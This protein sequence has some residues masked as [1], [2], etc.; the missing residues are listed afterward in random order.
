[1]IGADLVVMTSHGRTG[2]N[3]AWVGSVADGVLRRS[4]EPVL[5]C[6]PTEK[7][8]RATPFLPFRRILVPL[9]GSSLA[10]EILQSAV[11]LAICSGARLSL[12][13][14]VQPV[15]LLTVETAIP[16]AFPLPVE[17]DISTKRVA[18]RA[19]RELA[20]VARNL[21]DPKIG[22]IDSHVVIA[23]DVGAAIVDFALGSGIDAIAMSTHGR[24]ASRLL[25][26]SVADKVIRSAALPMLLKGPGTA[27]KPNEFE[28]IDA[29]F[30]HQ[31]TGAPTT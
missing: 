12:L 14:I 5:M 26:G 10:N 7:A 1:A 31:D 2:L 18:E 19:R 13:R 30:Q 3:R 27:E 23:H 6:R 15:Q 24:G 21:S 22:E 28:A 9:D 17:D 11:S 20:E 4:N 29:T 25:L 16:F 8:D